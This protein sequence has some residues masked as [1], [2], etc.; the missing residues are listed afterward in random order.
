MGCYIFCASANFPSLNARY[1]MSNIA[2]YF[3]AILVRVG[4]DAFLSRCRSAIKRSSLAA[5]IDVEVL[6]LYFHSTADVFS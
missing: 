4:G 3:P 5:G 1:G 2:L 6:P